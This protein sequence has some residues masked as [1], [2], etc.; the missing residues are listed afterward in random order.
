MRT[1]KLYSILEQFDKYEQNRCRKYIQSPYFNANEELGKLFDIL[2]NHINEKSEEEICKEKIWRIL[3]RGIPYDDVRFRKYCSD[4]LKLIE[5]YLAQNI[6]ENKPYQ[7]AV[8]LIEAIG[9]KRLERLSNSTMRSARKISQNFPYRSSLYFLYQYQIERSYYELTDFDTFRSDKTN[10]EAIDENLEIFY[11]SEKLK[12]QCE[13]LTRQ[14]VVS[15]EYQ[16]IPPKEILARINKS[17]CKEVPVIAIY[18]QIYLTLI[19][20][21]DTEHYF[22]LKK[23]LREYVN[24][25]P[26]NEAKDIYDAA[27]NY[28][29]RKNNQ[30][31]ESFLQELF[32]IYKDSLENLYKQDELPPWHFKNIVQCALRLGEYE[33]TEGFIIDYQYKLPEV[34]RKNAVTF[35]LAQ[36]YFYQKKYE[37][38]IPLLQTVEFEDFTYN[39][40][41]KSILLATYFETDEIEPLYSL[42]D[43]FRTFLNRHNDIPERRRKSYKNLIRFT[44]KLTKVLPGDRKT[45]EKIKEE[46][47]QIKNIASIAWLKEKIAELEDA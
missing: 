21:E 25:F 37:K 40:G 14:H 41:S 10:I 4:L 7:K 46:I 39:L 12:Y 27:I 24:T 16:L 32:D 44:K 9:E 23:L 26:I 33:W 19:D 2:V 38:V 47:D 34:F 6:Y 28:C 30:G 13:I 31:S 36:L 20:P 1:S 45:I 3:N 18:Y 17:N 42:M 22:Q 29:I 35:N 5:G 43:S 11:L 8:N 15:H